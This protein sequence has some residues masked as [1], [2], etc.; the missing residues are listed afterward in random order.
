MSR[1]TISVLTPQRDDSNSE[2]VVR[3]R[4]RIVVQG[5]RLTTR[6]DSRHMAARGPD[7]TNT[8]STPFA[9]GP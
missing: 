7:Q 6:D 4:P 5:V 1:T 9:S 3:E 8:G 2:E